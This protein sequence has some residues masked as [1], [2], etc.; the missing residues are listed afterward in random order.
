MQVFPVLDDTPSKQPDVEFL[1]YQPKLFGKA[2]NSTLTVRS[3]NVT[4][5]DL[6][7]LILLLIFLEITSSGG[8][9]VVVGLY[10]RAGFLG[11]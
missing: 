8:E 6:F 4:D 7:F 1:P 5:E 10:D 3:P 9:F 11:G 2:P